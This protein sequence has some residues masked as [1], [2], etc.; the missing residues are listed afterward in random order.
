VFLALQLQK[1]KFGHCTWQFG[2]TAGGQAV[3]L[4][5]VTYAF[6]RYQVSSTACFMLSGCV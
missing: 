1:A 2:V 4:G 3:M 5:L 6:V